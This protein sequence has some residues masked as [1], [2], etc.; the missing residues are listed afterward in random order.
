[1]A[2]P[3]PLRIA[4]RDAE[5]QRART[6]KTNRT[7]R[8]RAGVCFVEGVLPVN[9]A[10]R[11][12]AV[13]SVWIAQDRSPSAW[14][15]DVIAAAPLARVVELPGA[16]LDE[17]SDR[18]DGVEAIVLAHIPQSPLQQ[19]DAARIVVVL[20][21]P[22]SPGNIGTIVRTAAAFGCGG[23]VVS[24]HAADPFDPKSVAASRGAVFGVPIAE[25]SGAAD[26]LYVGR[27]RLVAVSADSATSTDIGVADLSG[28]LALVLGNEARGLSHAFIEVCD[29]SVH[30][31]M[32]T[33]VVDSLNVAVAS[34]IA[35]FAAVRQRG[36]A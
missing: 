10:L 25:I 23:V 31:G 34:G 21:R 28:P 13:E 24:G 7:K 18:E 5:F 32:N 11:A 19:L 15:R 20:D 2:R 8:R 17:L 9:A 3:A 30:I 12:G 26:M 6:L 14:V 16:L 33:T 35:L 27:P 4:T 29:S 1:M 36:T 22:T